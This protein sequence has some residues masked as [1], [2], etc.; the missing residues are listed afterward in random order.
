MQRHSSHDQKNPNPLL[1]FPSS[2]TQ[3]G[4]PEESYTLL[5]VYQTKRECHGYMN[6]NLPMHSYHQS[7]FVLLFSR[8]LI[9]RIADSL[10]QC[11]ASSTDHQSIDLNLVVSE[12]PADR[13][14]Q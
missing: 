12:L 13:A 11:E 4:Y 2:Y 9:L 1:Q 6:L 3:I 5:S 8:P 10:L 7:V 14:H